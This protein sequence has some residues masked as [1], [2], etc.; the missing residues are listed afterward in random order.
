MVG[1]SSSSAC[2]VAEQRLGQQHPHLLAA[3]QLAHRPFVQRLG[4]VE[5]LEQNGGVAL[6][7]VAVLVADDAFELAEAHALLVGQVALRVEPLALFERAPQPR[8]AHD[9]GVDGAEVVERELV[10]PED[11]DFVRRRDGSP[12]RRELAGQQLHEGGLAGAVRAGE[13]VA[14][15]G[16]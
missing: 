9:H 5:T 7:G 12:L 2:G 14:A 11:A 4:D 1:S 10:L 16:R 6:G 15:A 3:L 8:V 13:T